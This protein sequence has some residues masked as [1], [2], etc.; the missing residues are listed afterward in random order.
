MSESIEIA[1][2]LAAV[3]IDSIAVDES[4][5]SVAVLSMTSR[6]SSIDTPVI[7][8]VTVLDSI[9]IELVNVLLLSVVVAVLLASTTEYE[10]VAAETVILPVDTS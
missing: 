5:D 10:S 4:I 7:S 8:S 1:D 2:V 6:S 3:T 9:A